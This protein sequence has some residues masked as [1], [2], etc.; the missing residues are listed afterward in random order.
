MKYLNFAIFAICIFES[1]IFAKE[2]NHKKKMVHQKEQ[3]KSKTVSFSMHPRPTVDMLVSW[4]NYP[5]KGEFIITSDTESIEIDIPSSDI[6]SKDNKIFLSIN[7]CR[8]VDYLKQPKAT[9]KHYNRHSDLDRDDQPA[10]GEER[11]MQALATS[12][13]YSYDKLPKHIVLPNPME[14][15]HE[16]LGCNC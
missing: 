11:L 3:P 16:L 6:A 10:N 5:H 2:S 13:E 8:L 9:R 7:P 1:S 14:I 15:L 4:S 12:V